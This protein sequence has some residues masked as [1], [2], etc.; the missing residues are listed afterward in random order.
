MATF[1]IFDE[2]PVAKMLF[3]DTRSS[4]LWLLVRVYVGWEWLIAGWAKVGSD[5]WT[6]AQAGAAITGFLNGALARPPGFTP[7]F[8][9]GTPGLSRLLFYLTLSPGVTSWLG[10]NYWLGLLL[11]L[12]FLQVSRLFLE[13]L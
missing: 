12:E 8:T 13:C 7:M 6:G 1:K 11:F 2:A 3:S 10:E 4:W 9:V 5:A